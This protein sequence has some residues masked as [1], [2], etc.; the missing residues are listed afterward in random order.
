[1]IIGMIY[2]G[3]DHGGYKFK[4]QLKI[5][6]KSRGYQVADLGTD[7][8]VPID[9]P[10]IA[11]RVA[12]KVMEDPNNRGIVLCRSGAGVC[13]A[14]NK[15]RGIRAAE[16]W[17][18]EVARAARH[19]DNVNVLC[20]AAD[21]LSFEAAKKIAQTFLDTSFAGEERYKRRLKEIE[22]IEKQG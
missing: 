14:A 15:I 19:D 3:A 12:E 21:Y 16:A 13:I 9:Y 20:L 22:D 5:Y 11:K 6:L 18:E 10:L 17:N 7:S 1:M 4:E 8:E 2:L